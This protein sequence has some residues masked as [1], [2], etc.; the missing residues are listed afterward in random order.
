M[1]KQFKTLDDIY[2]CRSVAGAIRVKAGRKS[3]EPHLKEALQDRNKSL[4][5][6]FSYKTILMKEKPKKAKKG[7]EKEVEKGKAVRK[8]A[9]SKQPKEVPVVEEQKEDLDEN[10]YRDISRVGVNGM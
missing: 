10:G 8:K 2:T 7:V 6:L 9:T 5:D 3:I 1:I 4:R